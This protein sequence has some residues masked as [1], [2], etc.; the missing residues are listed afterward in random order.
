[1]GSYGFERTLHVLRLS[2]CS[3]KVLNAPA[4]ISLDTQETGCA[5]TSLQ[6]HQKL[7]YWRKFWNSVEKWK[8]I[9]FSLSRY[10][11]GASRNPCRGNGN[12]KRSALEV[13]YL[14]NLYD[15]PKRLNFD[16]SGDVGPGP[17]R[18]QATEAVGSSQTH[19]S[20]VFRS[21]NLQHSDVTTDLKFQL[22]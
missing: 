9:N 14:D 15:R 3:Q 10:K 17:S 2:G 18:S 19:L 22:V 1:M 7:R 13:N 12:T 8:N 16:E 4:L 5:S 20:T 21:A 11:P 6:W